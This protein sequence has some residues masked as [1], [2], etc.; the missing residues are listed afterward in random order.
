V[1]LFRGNLFGNRALSSALYPTLGG[2]LGQSPAGSFPISPNAQLLGAFEIAPRGSWWQ[3]D[4]NAWM[5]WSLFAQ[6]PTGAPLTNT[7]TVG[8][9]AQFTGKPSDTV[10]V[11]AEVMA[12]GYR[13][14]IPGA[15]PSGPTS[16]SGAT[17]GA[18][19]FVQQTVRG[20]SPRERSAWGLEFFWSME[21]DTR[22]M[23]S[24]T[25]HMFNL[26]F[27]LGGNIAPRRPSPA[28]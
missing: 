12:S 3:F 26:R 7:V 24:T 21:T 4:A 27:D 5:N 2:A 1:H 14:G 8:G 16:A 20:N 23:T 25:T 19:I 13:A 9:S 15:G 28:H 18:G 22:G 6:D 11:G 10:Q 17:V